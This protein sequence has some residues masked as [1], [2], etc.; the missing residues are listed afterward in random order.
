[1]DFERRRSHDGWHIA[2][3][4]HTMSISLLPK[5]LNFCRVGIALAVGGDAMEAHAYAARRWGQG[6][7]AATV[8]R[9]AIAGGSGDTWGAE[10]AESRAAAMEFLEAVRAQEI[11]SKLTAVRRVPSGKPYVASAGAAV[12][13]WRGESKAARVSASAFDYQVMTPLSLACLQVFSNELLRDASPE[14]EALIRKDLI[15]AVVALSDS[16]FID[17]AN[18]GVAGVTP[19]S[20][21]FGASTL[22]S[23]GNIASDAAG[24]LGLSRARCRPRAG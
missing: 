21:T 5:G 16:S 23:S 17:V 3:E 13:Y 4:P 18:G 1:M 7:A 6:S 24:A 10:L 2:T 20:A 12:A 19:P 14:A 15:A 22:V 9:A 11:L 8:L